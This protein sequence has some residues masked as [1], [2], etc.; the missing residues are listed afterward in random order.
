MSIV[1]EL[2]ALIVARN[3]D[4][5]GVRNITDAVKVL[6][7]LQEGETAGTQTIA[8]GIRAIRTAGA[9]ENP[10]KDLD[11]TGSFSATAEK[12]LGKAL[13]DLQNGITVDMTTCKITGTSKYVTG[14]TGFS[15]NEEEQSGHYLALYIDVED[16]AG[17][18]YTC[19][20]SKGPVTLDEDQIII[21]RIEGKTNVPLVVK[22]S[23][24]GCNTVT[25]IFDLSGLILE[26][27][28]NE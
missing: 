28:S 17:V 19:E 11:V 18:T 16:V 3:G 7:Q 6:A 27:A 26:P 14:Y 5:S 4:P 15:G 9:G 10:L 1:D 12:L 2:K 13:S 24:A 22:A 20:L 25:R 8:Q 21:L 23:K